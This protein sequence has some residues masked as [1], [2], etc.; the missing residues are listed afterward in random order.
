MKHVLKSLRHNGIYVPLY[1]LK[2]FKITIQGQRIPLTV[3]SEQMAVAWIRKRYS[4]LSPPDKVFMRNF[5]RE[6]LDQLKIENPKLTFLPSFACEYIKRIESQENSVICDPKA[7]IHSEIDFSEVVNYLEQD[8][9]NKL[10]LSKEIKKQQAQERKIKREALKEKLGYAEV[11]GQKLEIA[12]WTAE[13]SC[14]FAGRGDHPQRGR[15]KDGPNKE[16]II[17]NLSPDAPKP[18]GWKTTWE[19]NK[20]YVA[21]WIDKLTGKVKYVWFSDNAFLK[22]NREKEKFRKSELL[23]KQINK[24]EAYILK[25]LDDKDEN[26]R[27]VA[28]VSWLIL[29][30]NMRVGDEKDPDEADT[31]GAITLRPEHIKIEGDIIHF[32]FLGKDCVR[33]IKSVEAPASAIRNIEEFSNKSKEYLFEGIDSKKV[34]R[35]LSEKM[36]GLTA[37]VFRTW[38]CTATVKEELDKSN[39]NK[40]DPD[41]RKSYAAKMANLKVAEV[42]NHKRKIPPTYD[43]RVAKK[44]EH[45]KELTADLERKKKEGKKTEALENR[46]E[47]AKLDLKLMKLTKEY[48]LGTSL[49][50]YIDPVAYVKWAKKVDF[51]L[52]KFYPKTLRKKFSWALETRRAEAECIPA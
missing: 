39:V 31:V 44:E 46:I 50:S 8:K 36:P 25:N 34:S 11:D 48:N 21:K 17:L 45:L 14:L 35:F 38:R 33:W 29:K 13:P 1:D 7:S 52:E 28:T 49:K 22:Q 2:G 24:I 37:K 20:M 26:R 3:K 5:M 23:G 51:D 6:F 30:P 42:A 32:D 4:T 9:Q 15:W 18:E 40:K 43:N 47:K 10:N 27:K 41:Y 16:D 12:N 19:P